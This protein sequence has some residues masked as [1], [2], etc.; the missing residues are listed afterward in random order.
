MMNALIIDTFFVF[1]NHLTVM[2]LD[3]QS[4][5]LLVQINN[6]SIQSIVQIHLHSTLSHIQNDERHVFILKHTIG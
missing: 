5:R 1:L 4:Y 2:S 6:L 3:K